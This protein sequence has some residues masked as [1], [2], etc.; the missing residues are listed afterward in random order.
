MKTH[1]SELY[2]YHSP[3]QVV[4][5]QTLAYA[6]SV[7]Q[8]VNTIDLS[9]ERLTATQWHSLL[10]KLNLRAKD[11]LNR[12]SPDYQR[13]I[14]GKNW[15]DESWLNILI[16]YP[17]LIKAPIASLRGSAV[18]CQTPTDILKLNSMHLA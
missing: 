17:N 2:F 14:A 15:D 5:K 16:K 6:K 10:I 8:F 3:S 4:D 1:P 7:A 9:K 18:L 13:H 11:L 12:A